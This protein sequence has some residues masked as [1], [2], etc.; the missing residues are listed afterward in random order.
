MGK[1][2][3]NIDGKELCG[4]QGQTILDIA[5]LSEIEIPTLC[6]DERVE[7]Y[8]SCGI[9]TVE[10]E[11]T[12]KLLRACS[13][14][15]ANGMIIKTNTERV[16]EN[17]RVALELMLS[18]HDGDCRA[19]CMLACPAQTDCQGYV[20]LVANG[21]YKEALKL[22]KDSIPLPASIGRIC[23]HPCEDAC[24]RKL[25]E[26]PISI[27]A[28]KQFVGDIVCLADESHPPQVKP[29]SGK[30]VAIVGGG[31][32]G[33][34]AAAFLRELGHAVSVYDA[35]PQM[36]G[37]LRY[38]IP[39]Y[40]LPKKILDA[41]I[42]AIEKMDV[43]MLS[44]IKIG[45]DVSLQH[46]RNNHDVVIIA[47]GAWKSMPL[48]CPGEELEG[49][50]G[51]IDF[52]QGIALNQSI[53]TG[54]KVAIVGGGNT[55]MDACRTCVRLGAEQV[56][57]IY[58]R[59]RNEMPADEIE[60][61]EAE[62]EGVIFKN[63]TNPI[64]V[65]GENG[66]VKAV[67][68]Q[69]MELGMP[70]ASG[71]RAPVPVEGKEETLEV[72][73]IIVAIGQKTVPD[74]FEDIAFTKWGTI[75]ADAQSY[76]TNL[77][78]VFAVGDAT[79]DGADIA[80]TAIG[81]AKAAA[82]IIDKYLKGENIAP[83][84]GFLVQTE[85]TTEDFVDV[86]KAARIK[87]S[88]RSPNE[89][90]HDFLAVN[91]ALDEEAVRKEAGR[92]LECG[93][94]DVF[95]C[96]LLKY[97]NE[98]G[99]KPEKYGKTVADT[100]DITVDKSHPYIEFDSNKCILCGLCVR[101]CDETVG[102][103]ALG[104]VDRGIETKVRPALFAPLAETDCISCGMCAV[105][106]PTGAMMDRMLIDKPVPLI[107]TATETVCAFC[108]VGCQVRLMTRGGQITRSLPGN[109]HSLL[110]AKG[111][112]K[113]GEVL[114][115]A[116]ITT[117]LIAGQ[118]ATYE[119]AAVFANMKLKSLQAQYGAD[120]IA[121]AVS[122]RHTNEEVSKIMEYAQKTLGIP[123]LFSFGLTQSGL[124]DVL[125]RDASTAT[126][127]E[128]QNADLI[129]AVSPASIIENHGVVAMRIKSAVDK[130]AKLLLVSDEDSLLDSCASLRV[131][132]VTELASK[133]METIQNTKKAVYVFEKFA[134]SPEGASD[135]AKL[136]VSS[137]HGG[138]TAR[139]G[140]I[141][142]LPDA[143]SQGLI[144]MG[145]K[146]RE[147]YIEAIKSGRIRGLFI[148]GEDVN[149]VSLASLDFLAVQDFYMT[150]AAAMAHVVFP[151]SSF[152]E[153]QGTYTSA[154]GRTAWRNSTLGTAATV[155]L[156][157]TP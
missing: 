79:N 142:L 44:G 136:A 118:P 90:R 16:R 38:G 74:G 36:G 45:T 104:L 151:G 91:H 72:D 115:K 145:V 20:G 92:C 138:K 10:V 111:R 40:R 34:S 137:G 22:I 130:E 131:T 15:A 66:K 25:V 88:H 121:V 143:N 64:E 50:F 134:L 107:E 148:Y 155:S 63:L 13:T 24:R 49:V 110:C 2:F 103:T 128:M 17:R 27:A 109:D 123:H 113:L 47:I 9:C 152:F 133:A 150:T 43:T 61:T 117:P 31:P 156:A 141:Q 6:H 157:L 58:R 78:G 132:N 144:N 4:F 52:L 65:V 82:A 83:I 81:E 7:M 76:M 73:T 116:R 68:L 85:K 21:E 93:C 97:A 75:I 86:E 87:I 69:I 19:P 60:I 62:E 39:E 125:G 139:T 41:E 23:P 127:D 126:F 122:G 99:V 77:E 135:L 89:R 153:S 51:G 3:V 48:R 32:G 18:E 124:T 119:Q 56:Y 57:N 95:E 42:A 30:S 106:C 26:E 98:Y 71:R 84:T 108:S 101:I 1:I 146:P 59:T 147:G 94:L 5:R 28:I 129:V 46:L 8:A 112:F 37:M 80:I 120:C 53:F 29:C 140:I 154:D 14:L 149:D 114:G 54:R 11:G 70:D 100:A 102:A 12:P 55:A 96:R 33:L 67:R 105:C 35:M